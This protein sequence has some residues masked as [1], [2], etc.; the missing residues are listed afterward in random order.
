MKFSLFCFTSSTQSF[1]HKTSFF[2]SFLY[3]KWD[4]I[5]KEVRF[6]RLQFFFS[7]VGCISEIFIA[8]DFLFSSIASQSFIF[9]MEPR[10]WK[11]N[12]RKAERNQDSNLVILP[13]LLMF[14]V[15][16]WHKLQS[17]IE[18]IIHGRINSRCVCVCVSVCVHA[19]ENYDN[20]IIIS[21]NFLVCRWIIVVIPQMQRQNNCPPFFQCPINIYFEFFFFDWRP[22]IAA[23]FQHA[24]EG[25]SWTIFISKKKEK[26]N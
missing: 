2:F 26:K 14:F 25:L 20:L 11:S 17:L 24:H 18:I 12:K 10:S 3:L 4:P 22:K 21:N 19:I 9:W 1:I 23:Q 8:V 7:F 6:S 5:F 13:N 15:H 16:N